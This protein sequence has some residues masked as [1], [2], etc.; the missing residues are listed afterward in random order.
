[1]EV[2]AKFHVVVHKIGRI[3]IPVG[4]R[5]FYGI[6]PGDFVKV[7]IIKYENDEKSREET[8]TARVGE[9]GALVIPKA[10]REVMGIKP[11][12]VLEVLLLAHYKVDELK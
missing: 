2:L 11:G 8:F 5:N 4:T 7:K 10:L 12:D 6:E 9:Q 1:M 3:I